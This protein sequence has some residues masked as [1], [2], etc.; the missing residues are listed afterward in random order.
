MSKKEQTYANIITTD[1]HIFT[2][3]STNRDWVYSTDTIIKVKN[4]FSVIEES[5][6]EQW[7]F[8]EGKVL[9]HVRATQENAG[10]NIV[11]CEVESTRED[12]SEEDRW[13]DD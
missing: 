2:V 12:D 3:M 9:V 4:R 5:S 1:D 6:D 11:P 10:A 13:E 7:D 8:E